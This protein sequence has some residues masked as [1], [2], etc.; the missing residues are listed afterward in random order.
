MPFDGFLPQQLL[1]RLRAGRAR[2]QKADRF[3]RTDGSAAGTLY[4]EEDVG[5]ERRPEVRKPLVIF[6]NTPHC[7]CTRSES[8]MVSGSSCYVKNMKSGAR[9]HRIMLL[10]LAAGVMRRP[11]TM[12][13]RRRHPTLVRSFSARGRIVS[14]APSSAAG[15][16]AKKMPQAA[17]NRGRS[18][19]APRLA[20]PEAQ[21]AESQYNH[22]HRTRSASIV[23]RL[24]YD[25]CGRRLRCRPT[26]GFGCSGLCAPACDLPS[27]VVGA[28]AFCS[29]L[30]MLKL[31]GVLGGN[32]RLAS[33]SATRTQ[34]SRGAPN[35]S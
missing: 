1:G 9:I 18:R 24:H 29:L 17:R 14:I 5:I 28:E 16:A 12:T 25:A 22:M 3:E 6:R 31:S 7:R 27:L 8:L 13:C 32:P 19:Q 33:R 10:Q 20:A 4:C 35:A 26:V 30:G 23:K 2:G 15:S 21:S 34:T 11:S